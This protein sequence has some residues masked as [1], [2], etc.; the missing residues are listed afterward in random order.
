MNATDMADY[1]VGKGMSF[2]KAHDAVGQAVSFALKNK[3]L[4]ELA[5]EELRSF[6]ELIQEDIFDLLSTSQLIERRTSFGGTA[7]KRVKA[8]IKEAEKQLMKYKG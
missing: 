2:R 7:T 1:L 5:L 4:H 8:A 6:S 3:E